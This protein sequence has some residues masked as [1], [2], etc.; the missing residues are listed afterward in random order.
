[1]LARVLPDAVWQWI[2]CV[3]FAAHDAIAGEHVC[4]PKRVT[5]GLVLTLPLAF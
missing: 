1:V 3:T 5:R 2:G 4:E